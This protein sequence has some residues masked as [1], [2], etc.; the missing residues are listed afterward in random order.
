MAISFI[1]IEQVVKRAWR[2]RVK[3]GDPVV[4]FTQALAEYIDQLERQIGV[5]TRQGD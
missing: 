1:L 2:V 5:L 3:V 4:R